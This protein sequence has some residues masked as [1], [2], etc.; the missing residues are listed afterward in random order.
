M[1]SEGTIYVVRVCGF[2]GRETE[3]GERE[4]RERKKEENIK[5]GCFTSELVKRDAERERERERKRGRERERESMSECFNTDTD[6]HCSFRPEVPQKH[7]SKIDFFLLS[8][9]HFSLDSRTLPF[10]LPQLDCRFNICVFHVCIYKTWPMHC[11]SSSY[12]VPI[13][14][15]HDV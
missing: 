14:L 3:R 12:Q 13:L 11:S 9:Q 8:N 5:N 6:T 4:K 10:F 7:V 15:M 1:Y 2:R